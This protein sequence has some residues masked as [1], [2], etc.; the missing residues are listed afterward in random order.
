M[1]KGRKDFDNLIV[2]GGQMDLDED[3]I[4]EYTL[5]LLYLVAHERREGSGARVWKGFD[6]DTLNR[7]HEKGYISNPIGK[8]KSV[9]MS[10]EGFDRSKELFERLF[11]KKAT[12]IPMPRFT[13]DAKRRWDQVQESIRKEILDSVFCSHCRG[14]SPMQL[15]GGEM[16]GRSLVLQ[17]TCKKC[18]GEVARVIESKEE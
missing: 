11:A 3:K 13:I 12:V 15:R 10:E 8:A 5:A 1:M 18:G 7:L 16:S 2:E 17:G 6:W 4:D 9:G 14:G